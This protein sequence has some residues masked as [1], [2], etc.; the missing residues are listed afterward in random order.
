MDTQLVGVWEIKK[1]SYSEN[2]K[3]L[4]FAQKNHN[5]NEICLL[6]RSIHFG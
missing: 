1:Q 4:P 5:M 3:I 2:T 6:S